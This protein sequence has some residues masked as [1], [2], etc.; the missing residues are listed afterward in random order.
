MRITRILKCL[1]EFDMDI[2]QIGFLEFLIHET[3]ETFELF[4]L[5]P[6][7]TRFWIHTIK[8]DSKRENII[9]K[10]QKLILNDNDIEKSK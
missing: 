9:E 10:C 4:Q 7:L 8:D 3:F 1:G 6:S 5:A 2:Y